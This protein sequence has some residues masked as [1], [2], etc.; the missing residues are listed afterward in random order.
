M[1]NDK[2][3]ELINA[4]LTS[5]NLLNVIEE[6][7][8]GVTIT[9]PHLP[10]NPI[11]YVNKHFESMTGYS[12]EEV[13]YKNCRFLQGPETNQE[14]TDIIRTAIRNNTPASLTLLN[15]K[16]DQTPFWNQFVI[17]PIFQENL[18]LPMYFIGLQFNV[19]NLVDQ[20]KAFEQRIHQ[21]TSFDSLT[22]LMNMTNFRSYISKDLQN[23]NKKHETRAVIAININRFR[24]INESFG[25]HSSNE[26]LMKF[27][28]RLRKNLPN[29]TRITRYFADLFVVYLAEDKE[30]RQSLA[31]LLA[32][33]NDQL[34]L[35]YSIQGEII[36]LNV[37]IGSSIAPED[38]SSAQVLVKNAE[39]AMNEVKIIPNKF[40]RNFTYDILD[41]I[42]KRVRIEN[43]L[44]TALAQDEFELYYQPKIAEFS[45]SIYGVEALIRW[46]DPDNGLISP[47]D[48]IPIAEETGF[49]NDL[50]RWILAEACTQ[51]M[52]WKL[53]GL[54]EIPVS[55]NISAVQFQHPGFLQDVKHIMSET[56][57]KPK[58]L[59]LE[60]TE[61]LL[62]DTKHI[63]TKL[64][65]LKA[66]GIAISIDDFGTGY[67]SIYYLKSLPID[68]LKIDRAFVHDLYEK[69]NNQSLLRSM[70]SLG[71]SMDLKVVCEGVESK[72]QSDFSFNNNADLIQ[73]YYYSR[74]LPVHAFKNWLQQFQSTTS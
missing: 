22:G 29:H 19:T 43:R 45:T 68:I 57:I 20:K 13:M 30:N 40:Y 53:E 60:I 62:N 33:L 55:V 63:E 73:G 28:D 41:R 72:E 50:G 4:N 71:K 2:A 21:L 48:F 10:D 74:P 56:G 67:S 39:I 9:D 11:I 15:Y 5:D 1:R 6:M 8:I 31:E 61:T 64:H 69:K 54:G 51:S 70:I 17:S 58:N 59:E 14:D 42:Q 27:A 52:K 26:I 49:I 12:K 24:Y 23:F 34:T 25:E 18:D 46:N 38:G 66:L 47:D 35:P 36:R 3:M 44:L 37:R 65:D 7:G 32:N 16:K